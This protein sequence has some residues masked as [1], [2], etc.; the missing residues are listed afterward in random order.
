[1][2]CRAADPGS[3]T[4]CIVQLQFNDFQYENVGC[5]R[6]PRKRWLEQTVLP[7]EQ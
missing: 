3:S 6:K 4:L 2:A 5:D 1:M 7:S